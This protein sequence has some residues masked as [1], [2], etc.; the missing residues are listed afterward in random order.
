MFKRNFMS[1]LLKWQEMSVILLAFLF[2]AQ[3][4]AV[5]DAWI[6][7]SSSVAQQEV[8]LKAVLK[9][10][11]WFKDA[12][13]QLDKKK[14]DIEVQEA[15]IKELEKAY[16]G[17]ARSE[18]TRDDRAEHNQLRAELNGL[19]ASFNQLASEYNSG[20]AKINY[21]FANQGKLPRGASDPLQR[22]YKKYIAQ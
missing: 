19:K 4:C 22:E 17:K 11:E 2:L 9:K 14:G 3:G 21:S 12:S 20:M 8:G 1:Q 10:Y 13:A 5:V 6:G 7:E 16:S 15:S 18:W